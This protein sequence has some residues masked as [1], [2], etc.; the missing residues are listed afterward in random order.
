M[1]FLIIVLSLLMG[2]SFIVG[3]LISKR[4]KNKFM[5]YFATGLAFAIILAVL[6][7]DIF[8]ELFEL[9]TNYSEIWLAFVGEALGIL[10]LIV[11]DIF[12]PHHHHV[13][14]HNDEDKKDHKEHL[15]HIGLLTFISVILHNVL[16]GIAFYLV[17]KTSITSAL[18]MA[19]GIALHNIPLG[20]EMSYFFSDHEN[21]HLRKYIALVLSGTLGAV[22]GLLIGDLSTVTNI[23]VLSITCGMMLYIGFYELGIES[24]K[25]IKEKGV[26]EGILVG[27]IIFALI[28]L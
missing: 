11:L 20:I 3:L 6:F 27:A 16:E 21:K 13:H 4:F 17:G 28:L 26:I 22:I 19:G 23:I 5:T 25:N 8:P 10:S 9:S 24:I 7:T 1:W 14:K 15:Y 18:L 2:L 12:V